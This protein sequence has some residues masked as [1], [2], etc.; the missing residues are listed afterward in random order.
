MTI[1]QARSSAPVEVKRQFLSECPKGKQANA[2][3]TLKAGSAFNLQPP[4]DGV[5]NV[6]GHITKVWP[7][8]G[9]T[10]NALAVVA[11]FQKVPPFA[12]TA[13]DSDIV[14]RASMEFSTNSAMALSGFDCESAMIV[15]AFQSL[16]MRSL[17]RWSELSRSFSF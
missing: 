14:A 17:P 5:A 10:R 8:G 1:C 13:N 11:Y 6:R 4:L 2:K 12:A 9:I 3:L 7:A 15:I 16:P